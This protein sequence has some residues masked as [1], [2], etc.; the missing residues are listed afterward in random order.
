MLKFFINDNILLIT[1]QIIVGIVIYSV[2]LLL[3][4]DKMI[5]EILNIIKNKKIEKAGQEN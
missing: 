2:L 4:K 5:V 3:S 1:L